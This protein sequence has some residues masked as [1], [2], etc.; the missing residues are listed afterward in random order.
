MLIPWKENTGLVEERVENLLTSL[1]GCIH[2]FL[3]NR[4][5]P[6]VSKRRVAAGIL[7]FFRAYYQGVFEHTNV[8]VLALITNMYIH[9]ACVHMPLLT[10]SQS[11]SLCLGQDQNRNYS[12]QNSSDTE[13]M[14]FYY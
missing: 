11:I 9:T 7:H 4:D 10:C 13:H 2:F 5:P 8:R 3:M 14:L 12:C 6:L 1:K